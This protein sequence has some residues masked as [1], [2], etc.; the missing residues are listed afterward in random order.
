MGITG[1]TT[2][3]NL[4]APRVIHLKLKEAVI[5][6]A[7]HRSEVYRHNTFIVVTRGCIIAACGDANKDRDDPTTMNCIYGSVIGLL[8]M[9]YTMNQ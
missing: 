9:I 7:H 3:D 8:V 5:A 2:T 1:T 4:N 6:R